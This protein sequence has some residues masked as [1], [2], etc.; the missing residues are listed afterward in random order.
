MTLYIAD[1]GFWPNP[2]WP[3]HIRG[4]AVDAEGRLTGGRAVAEV[5]PGIPDG[6]RIDVDGNIWTS[7]GDGVQCITPAGEFIGKI[8]VPEKVANVAFG[9]SSRNRLVSSA[10]IRRCTR[11]TSIRGA[12]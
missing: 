9:G 8:R 2:D 10:G 4:F 12:P 6:F 1:S 11:S 7:A 5:S 3:H